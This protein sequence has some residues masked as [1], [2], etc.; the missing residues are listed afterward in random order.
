MNYILLSRKLFSSF[1]SKNS[2]NKQSTTCKF[3][4]EAFSRTKKLMQEVCSKYSRCLVYNI[5]VSSCMKHF[6][7]NMINTQELCFN[8][9]VAT[10]GIHC[11]F[12]SQFIPLPVFSFKFFFRSF[13]SLRFKPLYGTNMELK[14]R[15]EQFHKV[16]C[17][18]TINIYLQ[19]WMWNH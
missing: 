10:A 1:N 13:L 3:I 5:H 19:T 18:N 16:T 4:R 14:I 11:G 8:S 9:F 17:S 15:T 6:E 2:V 7:H 12:M